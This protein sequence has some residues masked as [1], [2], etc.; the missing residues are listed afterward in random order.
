MNG[1]RQEGMGRMDMTVH[2]GR[3]W[4]AATIWNW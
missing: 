4:S 1:Y 3:R 2:A